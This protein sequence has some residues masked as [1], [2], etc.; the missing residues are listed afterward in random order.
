MVRFWEKTVICW[1][2]HADTWTFKQKWLKCPFR[3]AAFVPH[4]FRLFFNVISVPQTLR[5]LCAV[6]SP[7]VVDLFLGAKGKWHL[8]CTV[9]ACKVGRKNTNVKCRHKLSQHYILQSAWL[10]CNGTPPTEMRKPCVL[11]VDTSH[12]MPAA[13]ILNFCRAQSHFHMKA[14]APSMSGS[15]ESQ[16]EHRF[17]V[18]PWDSKPTSYA[19]VSR[20][21]TMILLWGTL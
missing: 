21:K 12:L 8:H 14:N 5:S 15:S 13:R 3:I 19:G 6:L 10:L 9:G 17:G 4:L 2:R 1:T 7:S 18:L 20:A 11:A 16:F